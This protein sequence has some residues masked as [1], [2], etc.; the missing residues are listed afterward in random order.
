MTNE[1]EAALVPELIK[2]AVRNALTGNQPA[3]ERLEIIQKYINQALTTVDQN[4]K[5]GLYRRPNR[6]GNRPK[7]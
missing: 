7:R 5:L 6:G 4:D 3:K 2:D 1:Y